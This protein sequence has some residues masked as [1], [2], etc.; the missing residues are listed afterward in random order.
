MGHHGRTVKITIPYDTESHNINPDNLLDPSTQGKIMRRARCSDSVP[1]MLLACQESRA[2]ALSLYRRIF[3]STPRLIDVN[4]NVDEV[5][6]RVEM[7]QSWGADFE[8]GLFWNAYSSTKTSL[9]AWAGKTKTPSWSHPLPNFSPP[10]QAKL[11]I[12]PFTFV[13]AKFKEGVPYTAVT[14]PPE[15]RSG[16]MFFYITRV[17]V[18]QKD[19]AV[20]QTA[21]ANHVWGVRREMKKSGAYWFESGNMGIDRSYF[22]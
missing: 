21:F 18:G 11:M 12:T 17:P 19:A 6:V 8:N 15:C 7:P 9:L 3:T 5:V 13:W 10:A 4:L 20:R 1:A 16:A 14:K 22:Y 2:V